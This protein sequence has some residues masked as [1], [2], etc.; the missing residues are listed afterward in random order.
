MKRLMMV[1]ALAVAQSGCVS[2][3]GD[4]PVLFTNA[5]VLT[6]SPGQACDVETSQFISQGSLD[7]S[8]GG[9]YVLAM[10]VR[11]TVP[12]GRSVIIGDV[13]VG[14]G[15]ESI[16]LTEF[17]YSYE[18]SPDLGLPEEEIVAT[19]SV[20]PAGTGG[21]SYVFVTAF[22]PQ[23]IEKLRTGAPGSPGVSVISHVRARGRLGSSSNVESNEFSFPVKVYAS[24]I[25]VP[26]PTG[27]VVGGICNPGQDGPVCVP[28]ESTTTP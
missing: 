3:Q 12:I 21:D 7:V 25:S 26:C 23:A 17:V 27:F 2:G 16:T 28:D 10:G 22:G 18:A 11:S 13:P 19:Y 9:N 14:V 5:L 6:G 1:A 4:A 15:G 8:G 20:I 24:G